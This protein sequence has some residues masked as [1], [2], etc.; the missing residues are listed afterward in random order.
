[1]STYNL[2]SIM[3]YLVAAMDWYS[4]YV[5]AWALSNT[6]ER[7][8]CLNALNMA[9]A[10]GEPESSTPIKAPYS[11]QKVSLPD[12]KRPTF[13]SAW[14]AVAASSTISA[15]NASGSLSNM[16][17]SIFINTKPYLTFMLA[18]PRTFSST[19]MNNFIRTGTIALPLRFISVHA[20]T[21][22]VAIFHPALSG[23]EERLPA[24]LSRSSAILIFL[25]HPLLSPIL[26]LFCTDRGPTMGTNLEARLKNLVKQA[27]TYLSDSHSYPLLVLCSF[28]LYRSFGCHS[29][30]S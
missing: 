29:H 15:S 2:Y 18:S 24:L 13:A 25:P 23:E 26:T 11:H 10:Q 1:M 30:L 22:R 19:T 21:C 4:R 12:W 27:I 9:L 7:F 20:S 5:L 16:N 28:L 6:L 8:L 14:T 3:L 17:T